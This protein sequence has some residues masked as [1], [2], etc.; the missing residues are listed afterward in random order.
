MIQGA[1]ELLARRKRHLIQVVDRLDERTHCSL[2]FNTAIRVHAPDVKAFL[3]F[4]DSPELPGHWIKDFL[5][6]S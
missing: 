6:A 1:T 2:D 3:D 5:L 4:R